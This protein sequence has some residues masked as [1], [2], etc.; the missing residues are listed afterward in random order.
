MRH[1]NGED[2]DT[3]EVYRALHGGDRDLHRGAAMA[4]G[5]VRLLDRHGVFPPLVWILGL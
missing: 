4:A 1:L 5:A 2:T 3:D